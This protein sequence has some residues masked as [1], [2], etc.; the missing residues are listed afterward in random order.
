MYKNNNN[1]ELNFNNIHKQIDYFNN[2][3]FS[4]SQHLINWSDPIGIV[5]IKAYCVDNNIPIEQLPINDYIWHMIIQEKNQ[6]ATTY[7]PI[8]EILDRSNIEKTRDSLISTIIQNFS[9]INTFN[10]N[11]LKKYLNHIFSELMNNVSDH[12]QSNIGGYAMAQYYPKLK[13]VQFAIADK[14]CGF[15]KNINSKFSNIDNEYEAIIKALE[16]AVSAS[17][18]LIYGQNRNAG[19]GLYTL[20]T[21]IN[22]TKGKMIII[23]N[24]TMFKLENGIRRKIHLKSNWN[25]VVVAIEFLEGNTDYEFE[26]IRNRWLEVEK[27]D[28]NFFL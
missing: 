18:N 3:N 2:K 10:K 5:M 21:I 6:I 25:G 17:S 26:T 13:K 23:S 22:E 24:D 19:Y 4:D 16:R 15:L 8:A 1:L 20:E 28:D 27:E 12:S 9:H 11:D 14:G 7:T